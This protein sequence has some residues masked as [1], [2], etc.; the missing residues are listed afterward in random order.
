MLGDNARRRALGR[1]AIGVLVA[2]T[3]FITASA[4]ASPN[5]SP[6]PASTPPS[7][8]GA[9]P[10]GYVALTF[11]D[12]PDPATTL[13]IAGILKAHQ[14]RGTFFVIGALAE[15]HPDVVRR[16]RVEGMSVGNHTYD[17]PFLD[18]LDVG[19]V[20]KELQETND[21]LAGLAG[22][23]PVLFRA[24]YGRTNPTV[25]ASVRR[26]GM[27]EVLWT[28]DSDDYDHVP[29]EHLVEVA[30]KAR[31]G[32]VLLFHDGLQ[33]TVDALPEILS[34]LT[35]RGLCSGQIVPSTVPKQ[36]WVEYTG[37]D[38]TYYFARAARW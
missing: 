9:C 1:I 20:Q 19:H 5:P 34:N 16:L 6:S 35:A 28:Y 7:E 25:E 29:P 2:V 17:H 8:H 38:R 27:T 23:A 22:P 26:L 15:A 31:D 32:D 11:D 14:A 12:G 24:P 4:L 30:R 21:I 10:H 33:S 18:Q 36:A 13:R 3:P 37:D